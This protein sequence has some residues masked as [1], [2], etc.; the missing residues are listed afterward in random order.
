M[1][2]VPAAACAVALLLAA[3]GQSQPSGRVA[4]NPPDSGASSSTGTG[5][6]TE[7]AG[8]TRT[9]LSPIGIRIHTQPQLTAPV[10][11]TVAQGTVLTVQAV[12]HDGGGWYQVSG[13]TSTGWISGDPALTSPR[14]FQEYSSDTRGFDA[15]YPEGWNFSDD[16]ASRSVV[17]SGPSTGATIVVTVAP[18]LDAIGPPG[19]QGYTTQS[20]SSVVVYG[21]TGVLR[22]F[23]RGAGAPTATPGGPA[24]LAHLMQIRLVIDAS[25]AM[26]LELNY[27]DAATAP[28]FEDF[29]NSLSFPSPQTSPSPGA[30]TTPGQPE[31]GPTPTPASPTP[32]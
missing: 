26:V 9:V 2:G 3:C 8:G 29:Y 19:R 30:S 21:V 32:L 7:K 17:F 6:G 1:R 20:S 24:A 18:K 13:Q 10:L 23:D 27:D 14:R 11:T 4:T 28:L 5:T 16:P 22:T 31:G 25:R 15:L 12:S